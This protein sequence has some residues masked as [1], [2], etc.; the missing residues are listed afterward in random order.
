MWRSDLEV[1]EF[2]KYVFDTLAIRKRRLANTH[3]PA[4]VEL[5]CNFL[6]VSLEALC[7]IYVIKIL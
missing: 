4:Y 6:Y 7:E 5:K 1:G 3:S 2:I